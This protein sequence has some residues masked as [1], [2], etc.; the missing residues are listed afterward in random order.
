V[1]LD[2]CPECS[3]PL[4]DAGEEMVC[5]GCGV[6]RE[7]EVVESR[8]RPIA[9]VPIFGRQPL[10]GYMGRKS[11][12]DEERRSTGISGSN[13]SYDYLKVLS[14]FAGRNGGSAFD[15][16]KILERV[17]EKLRLP[18]V[19]I[20][21]AASIAKKILGIPHPHQRV[22]VAEVSA[23]SMI[24][25]CKI[26]GI[27]S[28][29]IREVIEAHESL[30]K[31]VTS[32]SIIRLTIDSPYRIYARRPEEYIPRVLGRLS[33]NERLSDRLEAE[34]ISQTAF[35]AAL[36]T[37]AKDLLAKLDIDTVAGKRPCALAASA[38]YSSELVL[39]ISESRKRRFTQRDL[40]VC[41]YT[42]EYTVRDHCNAIFMPEV[43]K[44][45]ARKRQLP[46]PQTMC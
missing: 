12:T 4:F 35:F 3:R 19:V 41:G 46:A 27:T 14:D 21:Q 45:I 39:S 2:S 26:E 33:T 29:S 17:G 25:A 34:G 40:A 13:S 10:G 31:R 36:R 20:L 42:A 28:V 44:L 16:V 5:P 38:V 32:S 23:Y 22:T 6:V 1:E 9:V 43:N 11:T 8:S 30:G 18:R 37:T 7:K 24:A 15:C